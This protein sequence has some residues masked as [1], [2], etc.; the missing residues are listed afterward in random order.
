M[1]HVVGNFAFKHRID[2]YGITIFHN[3]KLDRS[4]MLYL[5]LYWTVLHK[6]KIIGAYNIHVYHYQNVGC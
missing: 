5:M 6:N 1:E 2:I 4:F 3:D